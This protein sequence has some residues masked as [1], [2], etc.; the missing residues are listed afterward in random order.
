MKKNKFIVLIFLF[1]ILLTS[2]QIE[3]NQKV[4]I[5]NNSLITTKNPRLKMVNDLLKNHLKKGLTKNEIINLLGK[6]YEDIIEFRLL[7]GVKRPDSLSI[8]DMQNKSSK[9]QK[10]S[11]DLLNK[12]Y[13]E[14]SKPDTLLLYVIGWSLM[15]PKF[16]VIKMDNKNIAY[17]YWIEQH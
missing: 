5:E 13:E 12:W 1:I 9:T 6:P 2:C 16:L 11:L 4:W 10:N 8:L 17:D 3:F 7:K 15:D 14:N